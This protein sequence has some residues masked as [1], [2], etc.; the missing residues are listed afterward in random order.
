M[1]KVNIHLIDDEKVI[2]AVECFG[3]SIKYLYETKKRDKKDIRAIWYYQSYLG[4]YAQ[5][6][7]VNDFTNVSTLYTPEFFYKA[8]IGNSEEICL[9]TLLDEF[10]FA[11]ATYMSEKLNREVIVTSLAYYF[12]ESY[13]NWNSTYK[14]FGKYVKEYLMGKRKYSAKEIR[15]TTLHVSSRQWD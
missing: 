4:I 3:N 2:K 9:D 14:T 8:M 10:L 7:G 5:L 12:E 1:T 13:A 11:V 15:E 6:C